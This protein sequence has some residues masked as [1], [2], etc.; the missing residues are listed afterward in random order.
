MNIL[1]WLQG[2]QDKIADLLSFV[3]PTQNTSKKKKFDLR[4]ADPCQNIDISNI[5]YCFTSVIK[6]AQTYVNTSYPLPQSFLL[7]D[8]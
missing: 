6:H 4:T 2:F 8:S 3:C 1:T 7:P 5:A